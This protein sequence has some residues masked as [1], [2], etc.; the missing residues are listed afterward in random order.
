MRWNIK[1]AMV[2]YKSG[3]VVIDVYVYL[4]FEHAILCKNQFLF[5]LATAEL[6]GD[7]YITIGNS[8]KLI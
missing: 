7:Y 3:T 4:P 6:I 1:T 5:L 8:D 2:G